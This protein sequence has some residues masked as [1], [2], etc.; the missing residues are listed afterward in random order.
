MDIS[1]MALCDKINQNQYSQKYKSAGER[2]IAKF[3]EQKNIAFTYEKPLAIIDQGHT[4][5]SIQIFR[6]MSSTQ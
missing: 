1:K 3:L 5:S 4:N 2:R 6:Y